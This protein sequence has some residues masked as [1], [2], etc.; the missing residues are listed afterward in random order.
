MIAYDRTD[1]EE[2][3]FGITL[4]AND[5]SFWTKVNDQKTATLCGMWLRHSDGIL[6]HYSWLPLPAFTIHE[7]QP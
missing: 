1:L 5:G 3:P 2:A 4:R 7:I 6:K